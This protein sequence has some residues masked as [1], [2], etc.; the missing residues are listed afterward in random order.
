MDVTASGG[1]SGVLSVST[2][3][4]VALAQNNELCIAAAYTNAAGGFVSVS[5]SNSF[6]TRILTTNTKL[7]TADNIVSSTAAQ[8][9]TATLGASVGVAAAIAT[10]K[11]D[12]RMTVLNRGLRPHPFSPGLAR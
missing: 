8:T 6:N 10:F 7:A 5:W 1:G 12:T 11:A 2:G 3:T 9:S 4:T